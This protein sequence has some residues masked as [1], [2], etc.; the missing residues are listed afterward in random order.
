LKAEY[1]WVEVEE[2]KNVLE[3]VSFGVSQL[4]ISF[5]VIEDVVS[6]FKRG[7]AI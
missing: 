5:T 7:L 2:C 3:R 4:L 6:Y 1:A